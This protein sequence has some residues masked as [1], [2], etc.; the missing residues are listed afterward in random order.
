[1]LPM[2]YTAAGCWQITVLR[3][4]LCCVVR[5]QQMLTAIRT[6]TSLTA[7]DSMDT[8]WVYPILVNKTSRPNPDVT[9]QVQGW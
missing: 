2:M 1:M 5:R 3:T 9:T 6:R 8:L 7:Q 4:A